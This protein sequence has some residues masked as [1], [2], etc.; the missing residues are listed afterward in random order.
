ML[1]V[2]TVLASN[3][4][5][6]HSVALAKHTIPC[7]DQ[8][9]A[10]LVSAESF[11]LDCSQNED[12]RRVFVMLVML[13]LAFSGFQNSDGWT[14]LEKLRWCQ[15]HIIMCFSTLNIR[16]R[17]S[18]VLL[19]SFYNGKNSSASKWLGMLSCTVEVYYIIELLLKDRM[20]WDL[21]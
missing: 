16:E 13:C 2:T 18:K 21:P 15:L 1:A 12:D 8:S 6:G 7:P 11:H 20:S 5:T 3:A 4:R 9:K 17:K 19:C 14:S 10:G